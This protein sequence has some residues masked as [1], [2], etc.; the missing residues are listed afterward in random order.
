MFTL[1]TPPKQQSGVV[2]VISL[3]MLLLLTLIGVTS[4]Q[5]TSLEEKMA[6]NMR[7]QNIAFQAAEAALRDAEEDIDSVR[8]SGITNF[9]NVCTN[10]L[11]YNGGV[12]IPL[13]WTD[14]AKVANAVSYGT[15]TG[16]ANITN[17]AAQPR[18]LN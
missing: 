18:Y 2:L 10:G 4:V 11:C 8:I 6:G 17:L 12:D 14:A 15:Y 3:V 16:V 9:D 1:S 7:D 5:T 13:I